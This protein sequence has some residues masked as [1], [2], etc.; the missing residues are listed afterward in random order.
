[1]GHQ[2]IGMEDY[3]AEDKRPL[4]RCLEDVAASDVYLGILAW[5]YGY[6]PTDEN[7]HPGVLPP[8]AALGTTSITEFEFRQAVA[9]N[10][11]PRIL[12]FL[13]HPEA[14]WPANQFDATSITGD[15]GHAIASLRDEV[16]KLYLTAYFRSPEELASLVSAA[17]Y[18]AEIG[19]QMTL[20]SLRI[21]SRLNE[22]IVRTGP[23]MDSTVR[24]IKSIIL[25]PEPIDVLEIDIGKGFDWWMTRLYF[26][27]SLAADLTSI[28]MI[29]FVSE[30]RNF[31]GITYP[32]VVKEQLQQRYPDLQRF[33]DLNAGAVR[34]AD[35]S[36]EVE[37]RAR[38]WESHIGN[39]ANAPVMVTRRELEG[40]LKPYLIREAIEWEPGA[41][42]AIRMQRLLDWPMRFVPVV[43][44]GTFARVV[45]KQALTQQVARWFVREQVSRAT[46]MIR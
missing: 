2:V 7:G 34:A 19:R 14:E 18:R 26:L 35:I 1:M 42:D 25:G 38:V 6:I 27:A 44:N 11:K 22:P 39:E 4:R 21:E 37:R 16:T 32:R 41:N 3:V 13:L 29:V 45:D 43:E 8:G 40:W 36:A 5:R 24:T 20:E 28:E 17:V 15:H 23:V 46:S 9:G 33:A 30:G 10:G 31:I 12:M